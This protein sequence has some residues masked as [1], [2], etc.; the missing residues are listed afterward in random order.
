M[1]VYVLCSHNRRVPDCNSRCRTEDS[2]L[3]WKCMARRLGSL[4]LALYVPTCLYK[5]TTVSW[6]GSV[7]PRAYT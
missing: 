3:V 6:A 1:A 7:F 4:H 2:L 5:T